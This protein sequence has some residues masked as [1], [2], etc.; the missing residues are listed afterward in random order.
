MIG[1]NSE[2]EGKSKWNAPSRIGLK[3]YCDR[4]RCKCA[5]QREKQRPS[6]QKGSAASSTQQQMAEL[7]KCDYTYCGK[8]KPKD[9]FGKKNSGD[10]IHTCHECSFPSSKVC[11]Y[12]HSGARQ[13]VAITSAHGLVLNHVAPPKRRMDEAAS[14]RP[15]PFES[16]GHCCRSFR[17]VCLSRFLW[18]AC[19]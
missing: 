19:A 1:P 3:W 16:A 2:H 14:S 18:G 13:D 17:R 6:E 11:H 4:P 12:Q 8:W 9:A 10:L 15:I 5:L 7:V